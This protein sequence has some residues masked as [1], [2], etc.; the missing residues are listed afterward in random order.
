M[1]LCVC[2]CVCPSSAPPIPRPYCGAEQ[3]NPPHTPTWPPTP[4]PASVPAS[5]CMTNPGK[6]YPLKSAWGH[7]VH[8]SPTT[9]APTNLHSASFAFVNWHLAH[10]FDRT[11]V[12]LISWQIPAFSF[13]RATPPRS[14]PFQTRHVLQ[15]GFQAS[16]SQIF[17]S[18]RPFWVDF[19][20]RPRSQG[21]V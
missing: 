1:F 18:T 12:T 13:F 15:K 16:L 20:Q 17:P 14:P 5:N 10:F 4:V 21:R 7:H 19:A 11:S 3:Q 2:S 9:A 6:N 8:L